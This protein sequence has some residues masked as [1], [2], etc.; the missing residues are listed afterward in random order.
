M[1]IFLPCIIQ[2]KYKFMYFILCSTEPVIQYF[3][4]L[5]YIILLHVTVNIG[6]PIQ[7]S[8]NIFSMTHMYLVDVL[9]IS[10]FSAEYIS[11]MH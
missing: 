1:F 4:T 6:Y 5:L 7:N 10:N 9:Q 8:A 11:Q 2:E 3:S